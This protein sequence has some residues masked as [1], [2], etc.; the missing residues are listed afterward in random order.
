MYVELSPDELERY[1]KYREEY[2]HFLATSGVQL[3]GPN[4][5]QRFIFEAGR[6]P[7]GISALKAYR[8]LKTIERTASGKFAALERLL[9]QHAGERTIIFTAD[10]ATVYRIARQFLRFRMFQF[11][12]FCKNFISLYRIGELCITQPIHL[13]TSHLSMSWQERQGRTQWISG[14]R[15]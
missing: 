14:R 15:W 9:T 3:G 6:S 8:E 12:A 13:P 11:G 7:Q 4:G 5:W 2:R 1:T 10:N